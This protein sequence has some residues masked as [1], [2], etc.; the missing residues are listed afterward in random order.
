MILFHKYYSRK[1]LFAADVLAALEGADKR[2]LPRSR[3]NA[4]AQ[5]YGIQNLLCSQL[6]SSMAE[7]GLIEYDAAQKV[8][9]RSMLE[10]QAFPLAHAEEAY[11]QRIL[12]LP[13]AALFLP[14]A[15]SDKLRDPEAET[16]DGSI[17]T[18]EPLGEQGNPT[19]S[20]PEFHCI[21][22]A[23]SLGCAV[24]YRYRARNAEEPR[25]ASAVPWRLEYSAYDNRWW[26]IL[27]SPEEG[28]CVKA[29]LSHLSEIRLEPQITA[30][31][32]EIL[33]ARKRAL[34]PEPVVL[35]VENARNA[36]ERC[37]L[38]LEQ[39]QFEESKLHPDGSATIS[40]R[41][42]RYEEAELLRQ[43]LYLGPNVR[44]LA[45]RS[46]RAALLRLVEQALT[47]FEEA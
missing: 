17:Q 24:S 30:P 46:L 37:F 18:M 8:Y 31:E 45:P 20:Q 4:L 26:L 40:F 12:R 43:L 28:R 9:L 23:I 15:L 33:A 16:D 3:M 1:L 44:L 36:L 47:Q 13:Q 6:L 29:W 22:E 5:R 32:Q 19:L 14:L 39:K 42:Y 2:G 38:V 11:L 41:N 7:E 27:Y 35:R 25:R 10:G 34:M 21:L